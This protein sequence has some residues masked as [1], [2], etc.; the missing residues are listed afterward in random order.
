MNGYE[1]I[2]LCEK[3][4]KIRTSIH[5]L[6]AQAFIPNPKNKPCVNHK[7]GNKHNNIV[8][9]LEWVTYSENQKYLHAVQ[10]PN[11]LYTPTSEVRAVPKES[12]RKYCKRYTDI[13]GL[14]SILNENMETWKDIKGF[15]GYYQ[16]SD[17]GNVKSLERTKK[18]L[19][20]STHVWRDVRVHERILK[21][22]QDATGYMHVRLCKD[23][24]ITLKK[25]HVLV[26]EAFLDYDVS[27]YDRRDSD[28]LVVD[29]I[30]RD[31]T[32]NNVKNLEIVT[33]AENLHRLAEDNI[34]GIED[35]TH[36]AERGYIKGIYGLGATTT[37][38]TVSV[39]KEMLDLIDEDIKKMKMSR[40]RYFVEALKEYYLRRKNG[41][42]VK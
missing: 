35:Q 39:S 38:V 26:A 37:P 9:N 29:H 11:G 23:G 17:L 1:F 14:S 10:K 25:V 28:S 21:P 4:K 15:E 33:Q 7:D 3:G 31:K 5:R 41:E 18:H 42:E 34:L 13:E 8:D 40:S 19:S 22:C 32:D 30:N 2:S 27:Q 36:Y 12:N 16:V 6:V 20:K 24:E